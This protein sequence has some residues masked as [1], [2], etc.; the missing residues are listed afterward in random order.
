M[1]EPKDVKA[2]DP[3]PQCG[4]E[5]AVDHVQAPDRLIARKTRN[6]LN[7]NAAARFTAHVKEKTDEQ[8][9]IHC[10]TICGYRARFQPTK[11]TKRAA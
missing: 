4:G 7:P 6:A 11:S 10:C 2:G 9:V 3:C 8:G 1:P 5:F